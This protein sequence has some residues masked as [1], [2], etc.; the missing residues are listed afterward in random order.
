MRMNSKKN[1]LSFLLCMVLTA[2]LA[3]TVCGCNDSNSEQPESP[4]ASQGTEDNTEQ[5]GSPD[6]SQ[7]SEDVT[8]LGEGQTIFPFVVVDGDGKETHFEIHTD[9]TVVGDALLELELIA[10]D[11]S[12]FGLYVKTVNGITADYD[13]DGSYWALYIDG[14]YAMTG[15][16]ATDIAEG[17]TYTFKVE[18]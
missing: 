1:L 8:V 6:G 14:E 9:C 15:V 17:V 18:K 2:A 16:D 7:G 13:V 4:S 3:L 5:S 10:G 12:E 11:E